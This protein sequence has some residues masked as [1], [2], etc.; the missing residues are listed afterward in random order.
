MP[1]KPISS[2]KKTATNKRPHL[3]SWPKKRLKTFKSRVKDLK[4]RRPH[5]S[6]V[7]TRRRDYIRSLN[8][9]GYFSFSLEVFRTLQKH[10]NI[11][12]GLIVVYASLGLVL[13]GFASQE[14]YR[15]LGSFLEQSVDELLA[16]NAGQVS[17]AGLLAVA[18]F[19]GASA[20]IG[21]AQRVYLSIIALLTWLSTVWLLREQLVGNRPRLRDGLYSSAAPLVSSFMV[22]V[23][24][25]IQLLPFGLAALVYT[26]LA[27]SGL[28]D[29]GFGAFLSFTILGLVIALTL[30]W[31]TATFISLIVV[32]LPGM[33]PMQ[34]IKVGGDLVVGRR[35]RI[36]YR[37]I[38]LTLWSAVVWF[39]FIIPTIMLDR[40][41]AS[42]WGFWSYLPIVPLVVALLSSAL[43][44]YGASYIYL[45][46]RKIVADDASPA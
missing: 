28:V 41:L 9:P 43:V 10:K 30:Y 31:L 22:A 26:A 45:L 14:T 44:V 37:M 23:V 16:G 21:E 5:S 33:Y 36:M 1:S 6:F 25:I 32:T 24:M 19:S 2:N 38:W 15:T 12:L 46:Y 4:S 39:V 34:A 3:M 35:L 42:L 27:G 40:Y 13:G 8:L 29:E 17:Q 7:R 11:W 20:N 18:T